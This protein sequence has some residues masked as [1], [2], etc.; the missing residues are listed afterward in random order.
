MEV[1]DE[2]RI[3]AEGIIKTWKVF[4]KM[5]P[6]ATLW[7]IA[8]KLS[9]SLG[10]GLIRLKY[11]KRGSGS[12]QKYGEAR[13]GTYNAIEIISLETYHQAFV[14]FHE[15]GHVVLHLS[16]EPD[17]DEDIFIVEEEADEFSKFI[18]RS[19]WPEFNEKI[20]DWADRDIRNL[21]TN[22]IID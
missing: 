6:R 14:F 20:G 13:T 11:D 16:K 17:E 3:K 4:V 10:F 18:C 19:L 22:S 21:Y 5:Y 12:R 9:N 1:S 2:M 15:I 7:Y 8:T